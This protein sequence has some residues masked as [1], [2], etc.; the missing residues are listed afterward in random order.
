MRRALHRIRQL[1]LAALNAA[2]AASGVSAAQDAPTLPRTERASETAPGNTPPEL[3]GTSWRWVGVTS[4]VET[5]TVAEPERY[6]LAFTDG[7]RIAL[8]ADCNRGSAPVASPSPG[9]LSVGPM[10]M[11]RALCPPGSLSDRFARDVSRAV[12]Y[13]VRG[14]EL[15]LELP[16]DSGVL[17]FTREP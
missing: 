11:T 4:P 1:A 14:G 3:R 10:A 17:R 13:A 2:A 5:L 8:R 12:R 6:T 15:H 16:T 7:D 9:A